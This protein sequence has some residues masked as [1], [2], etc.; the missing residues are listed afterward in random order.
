[1]PKT[2]QRARRTGRT[3]KP[4]FD[5]DE[6]LA[7]ADAHHQRTGQWPTHNSG[8]IA[9]APGDKWS[10][11]DGALYAG[12]R[13]LPGG[14]SLPLLLRERR[15]RRSIGHVP[16]FTIKQILAW[17]DA[18]HRRTD[19]WPNRDSGRIPEAAGE[20]WSYV[21]A[22][23]HA[24]TRGLPGGSSLMELLHVRRGARDTLHPPRLTYKRILAWADAH[25]ARTGE[26][27]RQ[28]SG[29]LDGLPDET[30]AAIDISLSRGKR[31]LPG[32]SSIARLLAKY[33]GHRNEK[34]LSPYT[35]KQILVWADAH[36]RRTGKWPGQKSGP[37]REAPG[38]SWQAVDLALG[39]GHRGCPGGDSIAKLL[40]RYRNVRNRTHPPRLTIAQIL[41][42]AD[43]HHRRT[44]RWP[45]QT[46]GPVAGARGEVWG[47]INMALAKGLRGLAGPGAP[48]SLAKLL[49]EKRRYRNRAAL[50]PLRERHIVAWAD[51]HRRRT[52][53]WPT[54]ASGL[55]YGVPGEKW[56]NINTALRQG[57]RGLAGRD[58][59]PRLLARF[60]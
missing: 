31:G 58:S 39:Q 50:A 9:E 12:C 32:D 60:G 22:A 25:R 34:A 1:M 38:E 27:P 30:W 14:S 43:A 24:G 6:I 35:I 36:H 46:S 48:G 57:L 19:R 55:V 5:I 29:P 2:V 41:T 23:L 37:I 44:G 59:L 52:G 11:V 42:W 53:K 10:H 28:L 33:R 15:G 45:T 3:G 21:C 56:A 7:W 17:A 16:D 54:Q 18:H 26:W 40:E 4:A 8:P 47:N 20:R 13:G 49:A 51:A